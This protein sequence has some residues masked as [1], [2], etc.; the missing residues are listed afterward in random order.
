M[1]LFFNGLVSLTCNFA[2]G[3]HALVY[4]HVVIYM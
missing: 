3:L 2:T 4:G 1:L